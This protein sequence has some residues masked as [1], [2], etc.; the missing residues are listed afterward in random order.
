VPCENRYG[1]ITEVFGDLGTAES[2]FGIVANL[3]GLDFS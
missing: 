1:L 2:S 3:P